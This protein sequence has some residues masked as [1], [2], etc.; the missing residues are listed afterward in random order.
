VEFTLLRRALNRRIGSTGVPTGFV[1]R[2]WGAALIA[3]GA[4]WAVLRWF[5]VASPKVSGAA[6]AGTFGVAYLLT[7]LAMGL[8]EARTLLGRRTS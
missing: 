7:C 5:P 3:A 1:L 8:P 6:A 4:A 2:L